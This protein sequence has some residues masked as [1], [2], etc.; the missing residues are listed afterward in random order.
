[1][2]KSRLFAVF[3]VLMGLAVCASAQTAAK[4]AAPKG[5]RGRVFFVEP[6]NGATVTSPVHL[7]FGVQNLEI[8]PVP[9][10]TVT[11]ARPGIGHHHVGVDTNCLPPGTEIPKA[12]PWV[13]FGDGKAEIDMQLPPGRHKLALEIGD[14]QHK[15]LPG[16]CATITLNVK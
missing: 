3:M 15:T 12:S 2:T 6:K 13:H 9:Q 10:G 8:S 11:K 5:P 7:K 4:K 1:M 16:M 14:D